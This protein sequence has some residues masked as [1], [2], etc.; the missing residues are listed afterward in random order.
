MN[1]VLV[2]ALIIVTNANTINVSTGYPNE[3]LCKDA[4]SLAKYGMTVMEKKSADEAE[5]VKQARMEQEFQEAHPPHPTTADDKCA[6]V[7]GSDGAGVMVFGGDA[8]GGG[9]SSVHLP[10]T[11]NKKT[12]M[13]TYQRFSPD[14]YGGGGGTG[15]GGG[16]A[17]ISPSYIY[18]NNIKFAKCVAVNP[19]DK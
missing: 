15:G 4:I 10:C 9:P 2:W 3:G 7:I 8:S 11:I 5:K 1:E 18:E 14:S 17:M 6:T 19:E 16:Y 12:G 13:T